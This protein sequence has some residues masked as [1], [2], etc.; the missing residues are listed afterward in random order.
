M[1]ITGVMGLMECKKAMLK[2]VGS[3]LDA[4]VARNRVFYE[5]TS[6]RPAET[7]KNPVSN[8]AY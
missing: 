4:R 1:N 3:V 2:A 5:N 6:L 7:A 8:V